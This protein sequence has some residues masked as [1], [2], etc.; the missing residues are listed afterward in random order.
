VSLADG[1]EGL[2]HA[3]RPDAEGWLK[4]HYDNGLVLLDDYARTVSIVRSGIPMENTIYIGNKPYWEESLYKPEKYARWIV[5]QKNDAVWEALNVKPDTQGELYKY[6]EKAYTSDEILIF[7]R[8][9][10]ASQ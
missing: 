7:K 9:N 10:V 1:V 8:N 3:K 5:M 2:S 4:E 6:F